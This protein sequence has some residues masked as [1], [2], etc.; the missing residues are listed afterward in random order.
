MKVPLRWLSELVPIDIPVKEL[1]HQLTMAG[2]EAEKIET[3]GDGWANVY[4]GLVENVER[5]PDADRL[6]LVDVVAGEHTLGSSPAPQT[7][8]KGSE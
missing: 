4:V 5:H 1:A 8:P 2:L 3:I 7:S 6:N